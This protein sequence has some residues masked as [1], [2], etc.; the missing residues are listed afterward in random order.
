MNRRNKKLNNYEDEEVSNYQ[1]NISTNN[2]VLN[3][4]KIEFKC[5][6]TRQKDLIDSIRNNAVTFCE[7]SPGTGKTYLSLME[8]LKQ[9][10]S[11]KYKKIVLIKSVTTLEDESLG[12]LKGDLDTKLTPIM[13]SFTGN[14]IKI[15][16]KQLSEKLKIM[17]Y[18]E[19]LPIAYLRGI[20]IDD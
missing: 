14:I 13:Y 2:I 20:S 5:K 11:G 16:G 19:W 15:I 10:K 9:I 6:N 1:D 18:I 12:Y 8:G 17:G 3:S 4:I 7:G